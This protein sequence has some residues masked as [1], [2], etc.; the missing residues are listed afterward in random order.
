MTTT[1]DAR[2]RESWFAEAVDIFRLPVAKR[3]QRWSDPPFLSPFD[4]E[5]ARERASVERPSG[6]RRLAYLD[7]AFPWKRSGFRYHEALEIHR[8]LPQT[9]FFSTW[10]LTD[11]FPAP[12]H[13][14]ADFPEVALAEG[15][16]DVYAVFQI[17]LEG[18]VGMPPGHPGEVYNPFRGPYLVDALEQCGIRVHGAIHAGGGLVPDEVGLRRVAALTERLETTFTYVREVIDAVPRVTSVDPAF[19]E[20]DFYASTSERWRRTRP[21][22]CLFGAAP[23]PRKGLDA[24]LAAFSDLDPARFHLHVVGPHEHR[25]AELPEQVATFHGWLDPPALRALHRETHA[26]VSPVSFDTTPA[27]RG[28]MADGFP[29]QT[30]V[31]AMSSGCLLIS[32]NPT[33]DQRVFEAGIHYIEIEPTGRAVRDAIVEAAGDLATTR[34]LAD[35]GARRVRERMDVRVGMREKLRLMGFGPF[36]GS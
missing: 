26:V 12:V 13:R 23:D 31:D 11:D 6:H 2:G 19:T 30:A 10:E 28:V 16:T 27:G 1:P 36:E 3:E 4:V 18:I 5:E 32:S 33:G 9:L 7:S 35:A 17:F 15:I 21:F 24:V 29:T 34:A 25:R 14:L 8:A 22:T 20:V